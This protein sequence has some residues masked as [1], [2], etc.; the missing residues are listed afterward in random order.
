MVVTLY[1]IY[2]KKIMYTQL[3]KV[4]YSINFKDKLKLMDFVELK[5]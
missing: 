2:R 4:Q 3:T 1:L 5:P